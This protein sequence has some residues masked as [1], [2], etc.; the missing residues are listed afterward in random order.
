MNEQ[1][2]DADKNVLKEFI[3]TD[4][5]RKYVMKLANQELAYIAEAYGAKVALEKQGQLINKASGIYWV[6]TL[7]EDLIK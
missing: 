3:K 5:G 6:R 4:T 7:T 2:T 1:F